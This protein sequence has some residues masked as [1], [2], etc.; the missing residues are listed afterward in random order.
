MQPAS[1]AVIVVFFPAGGRVVLPGS[2]E[3]S[4]R[5]ARNVWTKCAQLM[6]R[7]PVCVKM[8]RVQLAM[9]VAGRVHRQHLQVLTADVTQG[10]AG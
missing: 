1:T 8:M 2:A 7:K 5:A 6:C 9:D 10:I 4:A 3:A